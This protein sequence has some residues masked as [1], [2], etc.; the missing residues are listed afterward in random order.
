VATKVALRSLARRHQQLSEDIAELDA[1]IG[2]LVAQINAR[3]LELPGV[4][5][6]VAGQLRS[7]LGRTPRVRGR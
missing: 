4:G 7:P 6:D 1:L 3:L 5:P 2:P